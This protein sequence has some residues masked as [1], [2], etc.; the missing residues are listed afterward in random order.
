MLSLSSGRMQ[1]VMLKFH[2]PRFPLILHLLLP[3][4]L[5]NFQP[6]V[7]INLLFPP[8][9]K[10]AKFISQPISG[11]PKVSDQSLLAP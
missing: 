7:A 3:Q 1:L 10:Q 11:P 6:L 8:S 4:G 2:S 9:V 5:N